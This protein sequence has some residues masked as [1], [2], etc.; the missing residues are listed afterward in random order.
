MFIRTLK[1]ILAKLFNPMCPKVVAVQIK[2]YYNHT[3]LKLF[4]PMCP[5]VV[6]VQRVN[7]HTLLKLF[8]PMCPKVVGV[9]RVT[10][11]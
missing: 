7:N 11:I 4:N 8:N 6:G 3:L 2:G 1:L 5:K 10:I 9:Q